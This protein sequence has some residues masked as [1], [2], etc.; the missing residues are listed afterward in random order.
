MLEGL[1]ALCAESHITPVIWQVSDLAH[2]DT[3][4][5]ESLC[6]G[7]IWT[8]SLVIWHAG[9][10]CRITS[11]LSDLAFYGLEDFCLVTP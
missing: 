1:M 4:L 5:A 9:N 2:L 10:Q 6:L 3:F 8:E 11:D 7:V